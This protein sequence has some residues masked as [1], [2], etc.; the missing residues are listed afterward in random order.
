MPKIKF[1]LDLTDPPPEFVGP[2]VRPCKLEDH[3]WTLTVEDGRP[4]LSCVDPCSEERKAGMD[5]ERHGP[6]CD[7][8]QEFVENMF[9]EGAI[10]VRLEIETEHTPS[11]PNGPEEWS[12]WLVAHPISATSPR[13]QQ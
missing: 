4:S 6:M 9:L 7:V 1:D 2:R 11:T 8:V 12:A 3:R 5:T 13:E 10:P